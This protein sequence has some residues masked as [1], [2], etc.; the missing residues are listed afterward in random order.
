M[1]TYTPYVDTRVAT[2]LSF[3]LYRGLVVAYGSYSTSY[4]VE[5]ELCSNSNAYTSPTVRL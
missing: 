3:N 1:I 4:E 2:Q 5:G